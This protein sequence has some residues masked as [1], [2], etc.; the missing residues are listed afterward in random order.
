MIYILSMTGLTRWLN[1]GV[2]FAVEPDN[3]SLF[4]SDYHT[5]IWA[6]ACPH[7]DSIL[8]M[9]VDMCPLSSWT[10]REWLSRE[11]RLL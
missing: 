7:T 11:R 4:S 5:C 10:H 8:G 9:F 2:V 6:G 1:R 3:S